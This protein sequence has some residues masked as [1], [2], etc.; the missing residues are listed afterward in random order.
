MKKRILNRFFEFGL[1]KT[2]SN[3]FLLGPDFYL[4]MLLPQSLK[5]ILDGPQQAPA[6][7]LTSSEEIFP[8]QKAVSTFILEDGEAP[9]VYVVDNEPYLAELYTIL[10]ESNGCSVRA[11]TDRVR[12]LAALEHE[13]RKPDLLITDSPGNFVLA[14]QFMNLCLAV[15]PGLRILMASGLS[16]GDSRFSSVKPDRFLQKPFTPVEFLSEVRAA[17]I[18]KPRLHT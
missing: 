7:R 17:L 9:F 3:S 12:A 18:T 1:M 5:S 10:L 11:F 8:Q 14:D 4:R 16:Q 15:C 2:Q 6:L 13:G